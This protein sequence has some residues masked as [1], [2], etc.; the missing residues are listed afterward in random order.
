MSIV[1]ATHRLELVAQTREETL[2]SI[3]A[4]PA[5]FRK[6]VSP[7]YLELL[8]ASAPV[9]PWIHGFAL[10]LKSSRTAIGKGGFK[11]APD[12]DGVVEIAYVVDEAHRNNGYATEAT[13]ALARFAFEDSAVRAVRAHTS[14]EANASTKVL[15]K[16]GFRALGEVHD[17]EDGVVWRWE[18]IRP[19]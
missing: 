6:E 1:I 11:G 15:I 9:D 13:G 3:A 2:A 5:E 18:L 4:L 14:A 8:K 16:N 7:A 17:P 12:A 10:V 19:E